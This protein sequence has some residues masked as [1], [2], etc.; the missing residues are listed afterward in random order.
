[1]DATDPKNPRV[2]IQAGTP[3][4]KAISLATIK[5]TPLFAD[6]PLVRQARLSVV[7]LTDAQSEWLLGQ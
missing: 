2:E 1:V 4:P 3:L 7:P 5:A 6:S